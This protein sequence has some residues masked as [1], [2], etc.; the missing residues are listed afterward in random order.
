MEEGTGLLTN[1]EI[2]ETRVIIRGAGDMAS[3]VAYLL[4]REGF[5]VCFTELAAPLAIRRMVSFCEA[6][7]DQ[8]KTVEGVTAVRIAE[9]GEIFSVWKTGKI[10]LLIDPENSVKHFLK[11]HVLVD[12]T[13][14]KRNVGTRITD[15]PLV[16]GLGPGFRA[17]DDVHVVIESNRG[18][19]LGELI[20]EGEAEPDTGIP[21]IIGGFGEERIIRSPGKGT[22]RIVKQIGE[23]VW[24]GEPV[25]W[26]N[27]EPAKAGISGV[28]RGLLRDGTEVTKGFKAGEVDP[29]GE[30]SYCTRIFDKAILLGK[31]VVEAILS[32]LP[33]NKNKRGIRFPLN[34]LQ[35]NL[36]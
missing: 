33:A 26:V 11:P 12:A 14:A 36:F 22:F 19:N 15:A 29:R 1:E 17:G 35:D 16:I 4:F 6:V 5:K 13:M 24:K 31:G 34:P 28:L 9:P 23:L 30:L 32:Q 3:G 10:P 27:G 20:L 2:S 7:Y 21:E 25:A 8:E 18:P